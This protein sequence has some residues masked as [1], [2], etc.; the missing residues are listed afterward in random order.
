[1]KKPNPE[2]LA[3]VAAIGSLQF[4]MESISGGP[5][6]ESARQAVDI[7][8]SLIWDRMEAAEKAEKQRQSDLEDE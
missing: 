1:M 5:R 7:Y 6:V 3:L 8:S 4:A 2:T